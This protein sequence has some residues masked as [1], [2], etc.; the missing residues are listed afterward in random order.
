MKVQY[1]LYKTELDANGKEVEIYLCHDG[2]ASP[3][4]E[5]AW[6]M[7]GEQVSSHTL[8]KAFGEEF[9]FIRIDPAVSVEAYFSE[10]YNL[11]VEEKALTLI[12]LA[13]RELITMKIALTMGQSQELTQIFFSLLQE[14]IGAYLAVSK[15]NLLSWVK[16]GGSIE[17]IPLEAFRKELHNPFILALRIAPTIYNDLKV[18]EKAKAK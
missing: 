15:H 14:L 11:F 5:R 6:L 18:L 16:D 1:A 7:T 8:L 12:E 4:H 2:K 13:K 17:S 3:D 9:P 10:Y